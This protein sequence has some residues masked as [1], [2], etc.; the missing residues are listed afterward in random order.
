MILFSTPRFVTETLQ[1]P[2]K[3][4]VL[5]EGE[6]RTKQNQV[7]LNELLGNAGGNKC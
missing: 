7:E 5:K 1:D 6:E 3:A 4:R 2:I